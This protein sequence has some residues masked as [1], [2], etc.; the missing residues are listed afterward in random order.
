MTYKL[1]PALHSVTRC[2]PY[3]TD[4]CF[5][6]IFLVAFNSVEKYLLDDSHVDSM[7]YS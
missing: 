4:Y 2:F 5:T 1:L 3:C 6:D 7:K